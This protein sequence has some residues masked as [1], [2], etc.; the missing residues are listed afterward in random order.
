M[1]A[2]I[3]DGMGTRRV[4]TEDLRRRGEERAAAAEENSPEE[5]TELSEEQISLRRE[6]LYERLSGLHARGKINERTSEIMDDAIRNAKGEGTLVHILEELDTY[7]GAV[8]REG[9][10]TELTQPPEPTPQP[11]L[12]PA[13]QT[14]T[15]PTLDPAKW[16]RVR[17]VGSG[18]W[19]GRGVPSRHYWRHDDAPGREFS[20]EEYE[21]E[22]RRAGGGE[23]TETPQ[24]RQTS[25]RDIYEIFDA[26]DWSTNI[27]Q[28]AGLRPK[29]IRELLANSKGER[30]FGELLESLVPGHGLEIKRKSIE[31]EALT[32]S[33]MMVQ[34]YA[35]HEFARRE[36]M[37]NEIS[38]AMKPEDLE[39]VARR[40]GEFAA[41]LGQGGPA[42]TA[43]V[44][45]DQL[46]PMA[47][48]GAGVDMLERLHHAYSRLPKLRDANRYKVWT[49][50]VQREHA[51]MGIDARDHERF[52]KAGSKAEM[53]ESKKVLA[54]KLRQDMTGFKRAM[55]WTAKKVT[56]RGFAE[57]EAANSLRRVAALDRKTRWSRL[58][59]T[60]WVLSEV[61]EHIGELQNAL[62]YTLVDNPDVALL[63]QRE[64]YENVN[65]SP[66]LATGPK[67]H[68][69]AESK[70]AETTAEVEK[71]I[72]EHAA[73]IRT[74][75]GRDFDHM[76]RPE[77]ERYMAPLKSEFAAAEAREDASGQYGWFMRGL[78]AI[79]RA[80]KTKKMNEVM[81]KPTLATA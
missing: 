58:S 78:M 55:D 45:K 26:R 8:A 19:D 51:S 30:Y 15:E 25:V 31:R 76:T 33:E 13:P 29:T 23:V 62:R 41:T 59:P 32:K 44:F 6:V 63:L 22:M 40:D 5:S 66:E 53:H 77:R 1:K 79:L 47:M 54:E 50:R 36:K 21:E 80:F 9:E 67:T 38:A 69:E 7:E 3:L 52:F 17:E 14:L 2:M 49:E 65:L 57:F 20:D 74:D 70:K 16:H 73:Q 43:E 68:A 18:D 24:E 61:N 11:N 46:W 81:N 60:S 71:R 56:G 39:L 34:E 28:F 12:E 48:G 37:L 4:T 27:P 75:D 64:A 72:N 42:R 35:R 10:N